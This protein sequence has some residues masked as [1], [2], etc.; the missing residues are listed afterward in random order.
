MII[1]MLMNYQKEANEGINYELNDQI[2]SFIIQKGKVSLY[3][4][5]ISQ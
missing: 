2:Q 3:N 4:K 1:E 5:P